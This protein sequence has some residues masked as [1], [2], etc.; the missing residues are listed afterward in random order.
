MKNFVIVYKFGN[1]LAGEQLKKQLE[2]TFYRL[3][4]KNTEKFT[5]FLV[6]EYNLPAL[7][8]SLNSFIYRLQVDNLISEMDYLAVYF[9][10]E[11]ESDLLKR[12]MVLGKS[13]YIETS[14]KRN[15][16]STHKAII[17]ELMEYNFLQHEA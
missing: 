8:D 5:Y 10:D 2:E 15:Y 16:T 12:K 4:K 7:E 6:A 13:E 17:L 1:R 11:G 14:I 3:K 9:I